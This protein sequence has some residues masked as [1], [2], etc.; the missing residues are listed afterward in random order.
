MIYPDKFFGD[1]LSWINDFA[2]ANPWSWFILGALIAKLAKRYPWFGRLIEKIK[3][4]LMR[5]P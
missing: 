2:H 4:L 5:K 1:I 3:A